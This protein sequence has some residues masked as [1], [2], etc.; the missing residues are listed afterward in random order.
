MT[1]HQSIE[2]E[3]RLHAFGRNVIGKR[4][5]GM[6]ENRLYTERCLAEDASITGRS[7]RLAGSVAKT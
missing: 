6:L 7:G 4:L 1:L 5:I 2:R 3:A